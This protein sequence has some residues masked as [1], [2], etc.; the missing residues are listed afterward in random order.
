M[1]GNLDLGGGLWGWWVFI[2]PECQEFAGLGYHRYVV[3]PLL[4]GF[5]LT[6]VGGRP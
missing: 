2:Q 6:W 4:V 5:G 1:G 3:S